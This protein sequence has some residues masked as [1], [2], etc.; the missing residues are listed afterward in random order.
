[1]ANL[2]II[3]M[4]DPMLRDRAYRKS[5]VR[6]ELRHILSVD[7]KLR[8][9]R[10]VD[11]AGDISRVVEAVY[12][13]GQL[14]A[15]SSPAPAPDAGV[16]DDAPLPW[17]LMPR[18]AREAFESIMCWEQ[19]PTLA[20][21]A[22]P[23]LASAGRWS[24]VG[25]PTEGYSTRTLAPLF[26]LGVFIQQGASGVLTARGAATWRERQKTS[27]AFRFEVGDDDLY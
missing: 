3:D 24:I 25:V 19:A 21:R 4:A 18:V 27:Q 17:L 16:P 11:T 1:M 9:F 14:H 6:E 7:K 23:G 12:Q 22:A 10:N 2:R 5:A 13:L 26:R 20:L 15:T 8:R